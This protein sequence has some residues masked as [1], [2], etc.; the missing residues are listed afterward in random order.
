MHLVSH[1]NESPVSGSTNS[2]TVGRHHSIV[3]GFPLPVGL[4]YRSKKPAGVTALTFTVAGNSI[5]QNV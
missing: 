5:Q 2:A 4:T 1:I 3:I